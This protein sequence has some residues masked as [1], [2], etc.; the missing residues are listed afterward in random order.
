V[1]PSEVPP[2]PAPPLPPDT[3]LPPDPNLRTGKLIGRHSAAINALAEGHDYIA[4]G[5]CDHYVRIWDSDLQQRYAFKTV[6]PAFVTALAAVPEIKDSFEGML[7]VGCHGTS[8]VVQLWQLPLVRPRNII[9]VRR[10]HPFEPTLLAQSG[11]L[12]TGAV[13]AL[14]VRPAV[15]RTAFP[16][17]ACAAYGERAVKIWN[18]D[19]RP[20]LF[21]LTTLASPE[22]ADNW[23]VHALCWITHTKLAAGDEH[24]TVT[25]WNVQVGELSCI[26]CVC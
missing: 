17:F 8:D 24:G 18:A 25:V 3:G 4:S 10:R 11:A 7:L 5:G 16:V 2:V 6:P 12:C 14:A 20:R 19:L 26:A 9:D 15:H 13:L 1:L 21:V 23:D 22:R